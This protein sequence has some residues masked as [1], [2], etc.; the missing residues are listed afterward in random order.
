MEEEIEWLA[1]ELDRKNRLLKEGHDPAAV[2]KA[3]SNTVPAATIEGLP[4]GKK[5]NGLQPSFSLSPAPK[6]P[7]PT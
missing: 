2:L 1:E 7:I 6:E 5:W 3:W 4:R